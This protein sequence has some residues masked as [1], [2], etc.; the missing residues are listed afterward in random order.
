MAVGIAAAFEYLKIVKE[1][2]KQFFINGEWEP[3]VDEQ[4]K[5]WKK[6][7]DVKHKI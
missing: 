5:D 2:S 4:I 6:K 1:H 3:V 7:H